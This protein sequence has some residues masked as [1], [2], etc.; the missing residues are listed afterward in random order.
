[1]RKELVQRAAPSIVTSIGSNTENNFSISQSTVNFHIHFP[2][3]NP[4]ETLRVLQSF[5]RQYYQIIVTGADIFAPEEQGAVIVSTSRALIRGTVPQE[6]YDKCASLSDEGKEYLKK[7]PA[8]ITQEKEGYMYAN[9]DSRQQAVFGSIRKIINNR[10]DVKIYY[11]PIRLIPLQV[12]C[13]NPVDF[14]LNMNIAI[15]DFNRSQWIARKINLFDAL[16]DV[17]LDIF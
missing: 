8:I 7:I 9:V 16:K 11:S 4:N 12:M 14:D 10:T 5:N 13:E 1:M 6:I 3:G 15:S 2:G 17:G